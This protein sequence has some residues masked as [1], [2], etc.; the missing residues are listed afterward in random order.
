MRL[1]FLGDIRSIHTKRWIEYFA[2]NNEVHL[3]SLDY[4]DY[5]T[6]Q[7]SEDEY[8]SIGVKVHFI[9]KKWYILPFAPLLFK[10][11][12]DSI[13]PDILHAHYV[14]QYGF[15]GSFCG[16]HPYIVSAWGS[17][18]LV[19]PKKSF[20]LKFAVKFA[21]KSADMITCD[22]MNSRDEIVSLE[23]S[24]SK[25]I[26][27]NHGIDTDKFSPERMNRAHFEDT[28][29]SGVKTVLYTRGFREI[30]N[31]ETL[32]RAI[33]LILD[34]VPQSRFIICGKGHEEDK[35]RRFADDLGVSDYIYYAGWVAHDELPILY[36]SS[37]VYVSTSLSDG[38]MAVG[39][40]EAM[41]CGLVPVVTEG[42]DN[43]HW[44]TDGENGFIIP[45][46]DPEILAEKVIFLLRDDE[47]RKQF[48]KMNR[49][50]IIE[51]ADY[52]NEMNKVDEIYRRLLKERN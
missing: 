48:A 35:I 3:I 2:E 7:I 10:R 37:D 23:D 4:L 36:A 30:Y 15:C 47:I 13:K 32:I 46:R 52:H 27:I 24:S 38:G 9:P 44:I 25:V 42:G 11:I 26:L 49:S 43:R 39:T 31:A 19:D 41:S 21:L 12:V 14:T 18:V 40:L 20:F 34:I 33:P 51:C 22:G 8:I 1:C 50:L 5:D 28:F 16:C 45:L 17:D 6:A 29:G